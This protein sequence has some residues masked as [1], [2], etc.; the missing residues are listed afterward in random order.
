MRGEET[1]KEGRKEK[2]EEDKKKRTIEI[3]K[4]AKKWEI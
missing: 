1:E 4:V 3:E 2:E